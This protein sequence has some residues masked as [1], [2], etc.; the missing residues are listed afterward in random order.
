MIKK[1]IQSTRKEEQQHNL[2]MEQT[3][4]AIKAL[5]GKP[6]SNE[7]IKNIIKKQNEKS[8]SKNS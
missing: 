8:D 5:F 1:R 7:F 3:D 6:E 2:T 4:K